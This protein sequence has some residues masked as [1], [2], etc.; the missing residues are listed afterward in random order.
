MK[1]IISF[2]ALLILAVSIAVAA[3]PENKGNDAGKGNETIRSIIQEVNEENQT[4]GLLVR[5]QEATANQGNESLLM[6][7]Q[8]QQEQTQKREE[9]KQKIEQKQ[10][11]MNDES[12]KLSEKEQKVY[13]NQNQ[14]R[15]AVHALLEMKDSI[16]GIGPNVSRIARD[17]NNSVMTTINAE[18][19]IQNRS[20]FSRF[21]AGGDKKSADELDQEVTKNQARIQELNQLIDQCD[22]ENETKAL[23][24][25]QIRNMEQEQTR[26]KN[27]SD[28]EKK[29][30]GIFGWLWK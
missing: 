10:Q 2:L 26:L 20:A 3:G 7:Q 4:P 29:S 25:E 18:E 17:F 22:C 23:M 6:V 28:S 11:E 8:K 21:F 12:G 24:Q 13:R 16:G 19:R 1:K 27:L 15:L 9:V 14:V 30:K 5:N